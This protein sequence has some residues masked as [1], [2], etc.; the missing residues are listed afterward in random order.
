MNNVRSV[1]IPASYIALPRNGWVQLTRVRL[2]H[3]NGG[4][5]HISYLGNASGMWP[6]AQVVQWIES[7]EYGFYTMVN[8]LRA[9]VR[10]RQT[11]TT[12]YV[13]TEADGYWTDNLLALTRA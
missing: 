6:R 1:N 10:V 11:A 8:G 9:D 3:P 5:E 2:T 7:G 12:K 13:Q 4:H